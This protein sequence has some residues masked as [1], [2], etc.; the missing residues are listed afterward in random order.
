[1]TLVQSRGLSRA[2]RWG[3]LGPSLAALS[4]AALLGVARPAVAH[5]GCCLQCVNPHGDTIP[6]AGSADPCTLG[7]LPTTNA[8]NAGFNPDGFFQVGTREN[9]VCT[10]GNLDVELFSCTEITFEEGQFVC[11]ATQQ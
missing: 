4:A 5:P 3:W 2:R 8:G 1:M 10:A 9:G 6:P 7:R 11:G